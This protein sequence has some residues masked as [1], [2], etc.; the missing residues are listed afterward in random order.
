MRAF[1][2]GGFS[3]GLASAAGVATDMWTNHKAGMLAGD[4]DKLLEDYTNDSRLAVY[5][6]GETE[7]IHYNGLVAI[8]EY[9]EDFFNGLTCKD[10]AFTGTVPETLVDDDDPQVFRSWWNLEDSYINASS[11][12]RLDANGKVKEHNE[13]HIKA[14]WNTPPPSEEE[15]AVRKLADDSNQ[16]L[17]TVWDRHGTAFMA[18]DVSTIM[19]DYNEESVMNYWDG[20]DW[21]ALDSLDEINAFF[22]DFF[23]QMSE[24][25]MA[26]PF[27]E[28]TS[29]DDFKQVFMYWN[30]PPNGFIHGFDMMEFRNNLKVGRHNLIRYKLTDSHA[31]RSWS[32]MLSSVAIFFALLTGV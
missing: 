25:G 13:I 9:Y 30:S 19:L 20:A 23:G 1:V 21:H 22:A 32:L 31:A 11:L 15:T 24:E 29:K 26:M 17:T 4:V 2:V 6:P 5:T 8:R 7:R 28:L 14:V 16:N 18:H 10:C 12:Y 3:V 27:V